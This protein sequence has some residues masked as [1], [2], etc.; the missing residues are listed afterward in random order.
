[1]GLAT[2]GGPCARLGA[3]SQFTEGDGRMVEPTGRRM[4]ALIANG[5]TPTNEALLRAFARQ[6]F[7]P[8][9]VS[10]DRAARLDPRRWLALARLDVRA[11]LDGIESGFF[12]L[13]RAEDAGLTLLNPTRHLHACHDKL[14]T[15]FRLTEA[16]VA[17]PRTALVDGES[18][19]PSFTG[20]V[21]VKP[22]FGGGGEDVAL[23]AD[24]AEL[25]RLLR[26]VA[27]RAWFAR[28]G[29]LVQPYVESGG[30]DLHLVVAAG[31]VVGAIERRTAP[32]DWRTGPA[33]GGPARPV[34]PSPEA[35]AL[36]LAATR[37]V[38][39]D[40]V[41]VE[42][43]PT[44]EGYVVLEL[45]G[46]VDF[47]AAYSV[48]VT[49]VFDLAARRLSALATLRAAARLRAPSRVETAVAATA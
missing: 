7:A 10:P 9:L 20:P 32:G 40:L 34:T 5:L 29:A 12:A 47:G 42:I 30:R 39:G 13:R 6:G 11:T 43:L 45:N 41:G 14:T 26:S 27:G 23:C 19:L 2:D 17:H 21:V 31:K 15:A 25:L 1:M 33:A 46:A 48:G 38:G 4:L 8:R 35:V 3:W 22:R 24:R 36:A 44:S 16:G 18:A 28:H 37:A 49:D